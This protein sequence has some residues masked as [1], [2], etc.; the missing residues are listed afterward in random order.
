MVLPESQR[1]VQFV[2][3]VPRAQASWKEFTGSLSG[4]PS[5]LERVLAGPGGENPVIAIAGT[6]SGGPGWI[7]TN[8]TLID[9]STEPPRRFDFAT[10][11]DLTFNLEWPFEEKNGLP[12]SALIAFF[13]ARP[14]GFTSESRRIQV[15][16]RKFSR[17]AFWALINRWPTLGRGTFV[18]QE[19]A[20]QS[21]TRHPVVLGCLVGG[22]PGKV[23]LFEIG[24]GARAKTSYATSLIE[25]V[26][27]SRPG[28]YWQGITCHHCRRQLYMQ[29]RTGRLAKFAVLGDADWAEVFAMGPQP[30][31][32]HVDKHKFFD[33]GGRDIVPV[34]VCGFPHH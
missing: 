24:V 17:Q 18:T 20:A 13:Q 30:G 2:G 33:Q 6:S 29:I 22:A 28:K 34:K 14:L 31:Y 25:F 19:E 10:I 3:P 7:A 9:V 23:G 4:W 26:V 16:H 21:K 11:H 15:G 12:L 32:I 1:M 27:R 5:R 8:S